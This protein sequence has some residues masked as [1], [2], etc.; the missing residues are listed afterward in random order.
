MAFVIDAL[1]VADKQDLGGFVADAKGVRDFIGDGTMA[2]EV[3]EIKIHLVG[4]G[5]PF[6]AAFYDGACGAAGAVLK[7][8]LGT[9]GRPLGDVL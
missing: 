8:N 7:D 2:Q 6:E 5:G 4:L 1:A 9:I 3:E